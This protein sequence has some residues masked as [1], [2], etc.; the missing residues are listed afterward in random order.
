M[1]VTI[2]YR[3]TIGEPAQIR[4]L[5]RELADIAKSMGWEYSLLDDD[6]TVPPNAALVHEQGPRRS[7]VTSD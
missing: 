4:D 1:G 3:G 6:W 7:Q 2:H 5:Q